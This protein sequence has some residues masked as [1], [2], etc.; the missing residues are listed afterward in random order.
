MYSTDVARPSAERVTRPHR[1]H[2]SRPPLSSRC[3]RFGRSPS[4]SATPDVVDRRHDR[5]RHAVRRRRRRCAAPTTSAWLAARSR[6]PEA[7]N[8]AARGARRGRRVDRSASARRHRRAAR[9][10]SHAFDSRRQRDGGSRSPP[11]C[12]RRDSTGRPARLPVIPDE[13]CALSDLT[14]GN[15]DRRL[16]AGQRRRAIAAGHRHALRARSDRGRHGR[17]SSSTT[18]GAATCTSCRA[19]AASRARR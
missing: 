4:R 2:R 6:A 10:T 15:A 3:S 1:A 7:R 9:S 16:L 19:A 14:R 18:R 11:T 5:E 8:G 17:A 12:D 13:G